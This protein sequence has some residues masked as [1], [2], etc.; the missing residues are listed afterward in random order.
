MNHENKNDVVE[1]LRA[2]SEALIFSEQNNLE[3]FR[4]ELC[5]FFQ[6]S[7]ILALYSKLL[8]QDFDKTIT[9]Q[10]MQSATLLIHNL[11]EASHKDFLLNSQFYKEIL[12]HPFDFTDD[13]I[14]ENYISLLKTLAVN[15][16]I[17]QLRNY[18]LD[19]HYTL[20]TGAMM[21]FN[22]PETLIKTASRTVV[23][24]VLSGIP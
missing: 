21:F 4:Y 17:P 9:V 23:L 1:L 3:F 15:L 22:Y 7:G 10:L 11:R 12:S 8:Q 5:S 20:F 13:E 16:D 2:I 24:H 19:N 14:I 6:Y 18:L